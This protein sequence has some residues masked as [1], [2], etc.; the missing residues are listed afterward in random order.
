[1]FSF[2]TQDPT[3]LVSMYFNDFPITDT[4]VPLFDLNTLLIFLSVQRI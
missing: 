2:G 4:L 1:M 3:R